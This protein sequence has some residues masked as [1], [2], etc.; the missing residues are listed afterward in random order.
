[1]SQLN[2]ALRDHKLIPCRTRRSERLQRRMTR[3][4]QRR[5]TTACDCVSVASSRSRGAETS[6]RSQSAPYTSTY[7]HTHV[8]ASKY[9][10]TELHHHYHHRRRRRHHHHHLFRHKPVK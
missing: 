1:M 6:P 4:D 2:E 7:T 3:C 10:D 5:S 9:R 8:H